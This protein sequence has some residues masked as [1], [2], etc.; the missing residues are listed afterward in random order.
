MTNI[1]KKINP[2]YFN[3]ILSGK[4]N[5]ELR[6]NDFDINEGDTMVLEE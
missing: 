4:K 2:E 1:H 3:A 5:F 6:L